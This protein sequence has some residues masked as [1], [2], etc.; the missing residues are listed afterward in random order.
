M[1]FHLLDYLEA[2]GSHSLHDKIV[3]VLKRIGK[4]YRMWG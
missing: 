2:D 4:I 3:G 1:A